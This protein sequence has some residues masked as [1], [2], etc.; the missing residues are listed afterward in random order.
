MA[1]LKEQIAFGST[2]FRHPAIHIPRERWR[3]NMSSENFMRVV[4]RTRRYIAEGDIFQANLAQSFRTA[5]PEDVDPAVLYAQLRAANPAPFGALIVTSERIVASTSPEGFLRLDGDEVET[6]PIKGTARRS[7]DPDEDRRLADG[8]VA[9]EKDR[10]ENIMIVD[11]MRNDLSRVC[12]PGTV[13]VPALCGLESYAS[14]HHLVSVVQGRLKP[15]LDALHL[16][17]A[18]FPGGS[19]TGAPKIR[20]MQ[21][22]H[23]L[24]PAP[25]GVYCGSIVH[26]GFDGSLRSNIAIRTLVAED[27][28]ASINAG[29]GIT[30]LSEATAEYAETLVK[31]ERMLSAFEPSP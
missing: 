7:A 21:I 6:R 16:F 10:A 8:L 18:C 30:L 28:F 14:V 11:L 27:G 15:G 4:E 1:S 22:I 31:A 9:S 20:A 12:L 5:L 23:E 2:S 24:E 26:F 13:D 17:A 25:R 3:P 19:I 29:G